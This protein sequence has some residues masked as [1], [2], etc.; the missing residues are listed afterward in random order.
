MQYS[1]IVVAAGKSERF[2]EGNKLLYKLKD[3]RSVLDHA[4]ELFRADQDCR[5]IIVVT[6]DQTLNEACKAPNWRELY[7]MGGATRTDS[8]YHGLMA[9]DQQIVLIHDGARC[10]L[11]AED[12]KQIKKAMETERAALLVRDCF[13]SMKMVKDGYVVKSLDRDELKHAQTPQAF[14]TS[15]ILDAYYKAFK[16]KQIATD[17]VAILEKYTDIKVKCVSAIGRN[18]K[19]TTIEDIR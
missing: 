1:A 17:D 4:L 19:I 7:C 12:L 6:S 16:E 18:E 9:V 3:G 15:D 10:Y 2:S 11:E 14:Y 13:D 5:Q 8:V